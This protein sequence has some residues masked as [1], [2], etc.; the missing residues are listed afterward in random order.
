M[1]LRELIVA[2]KIKADVKAGERVDQILE[3]IG[4][5]AKVAERQLDG[6]AKAAGRLDKRLGE[7]ARSGK[8]A[9]RGLDSF[10]SSAR[11][12]EQA[13][14]QAGKAADRAGDKMARAG[15]KSSRGGGMDFS[16]GRAAVV[17]GAVAVGAAVGLGAGF[18]VSISAEREKLR[19]T[20]KNME[21]DEGKALAT[22][23]R[24]ESFAAKTPFAIEEIANGLIKLKGAGL[25]ASD[26]TLRSYGDL[27]STVG[28]TLDD[29]VEA[30]KDAVRG[31]NER[32]KELNISAKDMGSSVEYTFRGQSTVV[33]KNQE[34]IEAYIISLGKLP[35]VAGAMA[36]QMDT[37]NGKWSNF[38]DSIFSAIDASMQS[39]GALDEMKGL[40]DDL[41]GSGTDAAGVFGGFL[42]DSIKDLRTW[43]R[44]LTREQVQAWFQRVADTVGSTITALLALAGVIMQIIT[45]FGEF[46]ES[47]TGMD[48]TI[49]ILIIGLGALMLAGG[50]L[51]GLFA[52]VG[53]AAIK[54]GMDA[55][56]SAD[57][58]RSMY[59]EW[60]KTKALWTSKGLMDEDGGTSTGE[61]D[62]GLGDSSMIDSL[63]KVKKA[64]QTGFG[65][66]FFVDSETQAKQLGL[67]EEAKPGESLSERTARI[68]K[69]NG[70]SADELLATRGGSARV[71]VNREAG[72]LLDVL[73]EKRS[74][75]LYD[76]ATAAE[77]RGLDSQAVDTV[78]AARSAELDAR[79][80][81][82]AAAFTTS[83]RKG[84]DLDKALEAGLSELED[85]TKKRK[86]GHKKK[87]KKEADILQALGLK[88]P[89]S[90]LE[91]RPAPQS[92]MIQTTVVVKAAENIPV[93]VTMPAGS[94][95][96]ETAQTVGNEVGK[97]VDAAAREQLTKIFDDVW[98][99][100]WA[101]L[102][103]ARGGGRTPKS[104]KQRGKAS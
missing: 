63:D 60:R 5:R 38:K 94:T 2:I 79:S 31:E 29:V 48:N 13:A 51:P 27:G 8:A 70:M 6:A 93:T 95:L 44:S 56:S 103:Q 49:Q 100:R 69:T 91:N 97:A 14:E 18:A 64:N 42:A 39:S 74:K 10:T 53:A 50:G 36:G 96:S 41:T 78:V 46:G 45:A 85:P 88:G 101:A 76:T 24:I 102:A 75:D 16:G 87:E 30:A 98:S 92:L 12:A 4:A 19:T 58:F 26:E 11:K 25:D 72:A 47:A 57:G 28:K 20:L 80:N 3:G 89:G 22:F 82:A 23:A 65:E 71:G 7:T 15:A 68:Q 67:I 62:R 34:A 35:G 55:E 104:A 86:G 59:A 90:I 1:R 21:G 17:G 66:E 37:L 99:L 9:G 32:L 73:E 54:M 77:K 81:K 52:A 33:A 83:L 43:I 84:G 61:I 40:V